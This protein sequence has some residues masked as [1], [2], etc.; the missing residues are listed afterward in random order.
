MPLQDVTVTIDISK[1]SSLTGLGT[2][3]I[4]V[5]KTEQ[6]LTKNLMI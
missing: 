6:V 4:L 3:L 1:P 5:K 2:A